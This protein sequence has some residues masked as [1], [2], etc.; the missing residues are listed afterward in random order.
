MEIS[1][2]EAIEFELNRLTEQESLSVA[3]NQW[4]RATLYLETR[5]LMPSNK[6]FGDWAKSRSTDVGLTDSENVIKKLYLSA[7]YLTREQY[8]SLGYACSAELMNITAWEHCPDQ[9]LELANQRMISRKFREAMKPISATAKVL[10]ENAKIAEALVKAA[11]KAAK[12]DAPKKKKPTLSEQV[13]QLTIELG[14]ERSTYIYSEENFFNPDEGIKGLQLNKLSLGG[15]YAD[16]FFGVDK[17]E[18]TSESV[19]SNFRLLALKYHPDHGSDSEIMVLINRLRAHYK[20]VL[21]THQMWA[22]EARIL[23]MAIS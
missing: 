15:K 14:I 18:L 12:R 16:L 2:L 1:R 17:L 20:T 6:A 4:Q 10:A 8:L 7:R 22:D 13:K 9:M 3:E 5:E 19:H 21:E 23:E 11:E